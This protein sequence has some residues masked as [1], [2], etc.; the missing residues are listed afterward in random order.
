[1]RGAAVA[2][3]TLAVAAL[4]FAARADALIY[5]A[6]AA[7]KT[8]TIGR[9]NLDGTGANPG[10]IK[11]V[12][13]F[14]NGVAVDGAHIYWTV[15]GTQFSPNSIGRAD[16][17]GANVNPSFI[18]R[19]RNA[20]EAV[21]VDGAHVYWTAL[22]NQSIGRAN[23][24]GTGADEDFTGGADNPTGIA[25]GNGHLYWSNFVSNA[26]GSANV[27]GSMVNQSLVSGAFGPEGVAVDALTSA[28]RPR[29]RS[30]TSSPRSPKADSRAG[31]S[32]ACWRSSRARSESSTPTI[33]TAP[34][35]A[36]GPNQRSP[37]PEREE[38]RGRLRR[39]PDRGGHGGARRRGLR[40]ELTACAR[41]N[42]AQ[43][44]VSATW[45]IRPW[46][47]PM[48][49][50]YRPT[51]RGRLAGGRSVLIPRS[52]DASA[53]ARW[54]RCS[55]SVMGVP[56]VRTTRVVSCLLMLPRPPSP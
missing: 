55:A 20:A 19:L 29:R 34:A 18:P 53:S 7:V 36:S 13:G 37:G 32:A 49:G 12:G 56:F 11:V 24:D 42:R 6:N 43:V 47:E 46:P 38:A 51:P 52:S 10:F 2:F 5:W 23:L 26:I 54:R 44:L 35:A 41:G 17:S 27:D 15:I 25:V 39:R 14:P 21:V 30:P 31:P 28:P 9:A 45:R 48:S 3:A 33:S 1:M 50:R 22:L 40:H 4:A 16:V 8:D